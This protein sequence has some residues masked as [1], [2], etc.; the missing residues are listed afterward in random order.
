M[1]KTILT[2]FKH[3]TRII[4]SYFLFRLC[5]QNQDHYY[6]FKKEEKKIKGRNSP[7]IG[8]RLELLLNNELQHFSKR[9]F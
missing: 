8:K 2:R 1:N 5:G 7:K 6:V 9:L 4:F 3:S